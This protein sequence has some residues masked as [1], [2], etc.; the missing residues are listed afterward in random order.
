MKKLKIHEIALR[1]G[2]ENGKEREGERQTEREKQCK[3]RRQGEAT[4]QL[5]II[6]RGTSRRLS[7]ERDRGVGVARCKPLDTH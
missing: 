4:M 1:K 3:I 5:D 6:I 7:T 2:Q